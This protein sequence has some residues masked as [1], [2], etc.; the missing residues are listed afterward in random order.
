MRRHVWESLRADERLIRAKITV[1]TLLIYFLASAVAIGLVKTFEPSSI[2]KHE[3]RTQIST[4]AQ[5]L[6]QIRRLGDVR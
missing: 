2:A 3:D 4:A 1:F 5:A 6:P